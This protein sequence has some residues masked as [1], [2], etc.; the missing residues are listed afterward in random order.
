MSLTS[1]ITRVQK[2]GSAF[3]AAAMAATVGTALAFEH[4]G[5]YLPCKLCLE[6]RIPYYIGVPV[7]V[8]AL[9]SWVLRLPAVVTRILI[10]AGGALMLWGFVLAGYHA[11][12]EWAWW[13]GP[14][15]CASPI[16]PSTGGSLLDQLNAVIPPSCSEA[17]WRFLGLSFAGWNFIASG[18]LAVMAFVTA[19]RK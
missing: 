1:P 2:L 4:I 8:L 12:V 17:S 3:L 14:A 7:M 9:I 11:G 15:D 6:Q 18:F 16:A 10:L 5:G 13:E 19:F